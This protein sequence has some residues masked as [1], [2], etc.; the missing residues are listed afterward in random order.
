MTAETAIVVTSINRPNAVMEELARG[1]LDAGMSFIVIGDTKSPLDFHLD[2]SVF[3]DVDA[4]RASGFALAVACPTRHYSRKN[5]GYLQA[6]RDGANLII[7]T[8]DDN[9]PRPAF[10]SRRNRRVIS[11][12]VS[13]RGWAN[14]YSY[15][16]A[17]LIWP[18]GLPL[19]AIHN[20]LPAYED[21]ALIEHDCPIQQGLAD[22]N[23]DVDAI[24]RLVLPLPQCFRNDRRVALARGVLCPFNSQNTS[25]WRDAFSLLFLPSHCSF[26]MTDIWRSLVA[27]R[28]GWE[29]EWAV[30]FHGPTVWQERNKHDLMRDF[31]DEIPGYTHNRRIADALDA[32]RLAPGRDNIPDNL[33]RC[34]RALIALGVI[35]SDEI[36]LL[37]AWLGDLTKLRVI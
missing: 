29:N 25:W 3:Y 15:F 9:H 12:R 2:G 14:V 31:N 35:A 23:P 20:R 21:L 18:R 34:Y 16:T 27:Q 7:E 5:I 32:L 36:G 33:H 30:L 19:D 24:Y 22:E 11:A 37:E 6:I 1:A 17:S 26:R 10:F 4:Q 13:Q 8:D 28:I